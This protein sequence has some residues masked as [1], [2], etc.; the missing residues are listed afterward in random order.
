MPA[1]TNALELVF[2]HSLG[3][4]GYVAT[5]MVP[6]I[7]CVRAVTFGDP[8]AIMWLDAS[9]TVWKVLLAQLAFEV[10]ADAAVWALEMKG[11]QH[12][13][14]SARFTA[15]NPLS[16]TSFRDF[17]HRGYAVAFG[18]GGMFVYAVFIAVLGP[19]FVTGLCRNFAPNATHIW[20]IG[21]LAGECANATGTGTL[22][23]GTVPLPAVAP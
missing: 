14:L 15:D 8:R 1:E 5:M 22:P 11:L 10:L 23:N 9:P 21:A 4:A 12:F 19:A 16:N 3:G 2:F 20:V 7:G 18:M 13:T 17:D 6:C